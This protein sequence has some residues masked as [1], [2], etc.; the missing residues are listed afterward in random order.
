MKYVLIINPKSGQKNHKLILKEL[1]K[2]FL[3]KDLVIKVTTKQGDA[4]TYAKKAKA[5]VVIAAGGDGTVNE[6]INGLMQK[7]INSRP[8]LGIIPAGTSNMVARSLSI[9]KNLAK[10][11][12][13]ISN[14]RRKDLDIGK[15]NKRFFAIGCG[16][17]LDAEMYKNVEPK[18]KKIFGEVAYPLSFIKTVFNY[19]PHR[20][21]IRINHESHYGYYVL[22]CNITKFHKLFDFQATILFS[23]GLS[24]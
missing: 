11:V 3:G 8:R 24:C 9:P 2:H 13:I 10:A 18:I 20:L 21:K 1:R 4:I 7:S 23:T 12:E 6:V 22:I 14:N 19:K 5:D 16:V 15:V 17:G